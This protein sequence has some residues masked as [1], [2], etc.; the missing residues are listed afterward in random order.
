MARMAERYES[1][2]TQI[3]INRGHIQAHMTMKFDGIIQQ[4]ILIHKDQ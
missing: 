2:I 3:I 4:G 1:A